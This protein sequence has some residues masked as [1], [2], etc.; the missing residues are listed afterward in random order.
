MMGRI[1]KPAACSLAQ[2][3]YIVNS[4]PQE[5]FGF[6]SVARKLTGIVRVWVCALAA[7]ALAAPACQ[8]QQLSFSTITA[9]LRSLSVFRVVHDGAGSLLP[10]SAN[11]D[12]PL[13]LVLI[14]MAAVAVLVAWSWSAYLLI[15]QRRKLGQKFAR[16][17]EDLE[18]EKDDLLRTR[19]EM[20]QFAERDALTGLWNHRIIVE[21]LRQEVDRSGRE[22]TPLSVILIDLDQFKN[23][24]D[25]YGHPAGNMVLREIAQLFER[26]V[27]SYDWVGRYGGEEFLVILPGSGFF[28]ARL[29]AEQLRAAVEAAAILDGERTILITASFGVASGFAATSEALIRAAD[30]SLYRAKKNGRNCVIAMEVMPAGSAEE[31]G[32]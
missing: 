21:R 9:G 4:F 23:V 16:H 6:G 25:T 15:W 28:G 12:V 26:S 3:G 20:R 22:R 17:I 29:R 19:D 24:N 5:G 18:R 31:A 13:P 8:G 1:N 11:L 27:R 32:D 2:A 10:G 14:L 7:P 30:T